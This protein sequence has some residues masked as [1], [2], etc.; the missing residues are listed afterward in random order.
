MVTA[1]RIGIFLS[2]NDISSL[3]G[4]HLI[5]RIFTG[6][7]LS[8]APLTA[9]CVR[10]A[11]LFEFHARRFI[12]AMDIKLLDSLKFFIRSASFLKLERTLS[13]YMSLSMTS[14]AG[15]CLLFS[16]CL[17][18]VAL[19]MNGEQVAPNSTDLKR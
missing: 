17:R 13:T 6:I 12:P 16:R 4:S 18:M 11:T 7:S 1:S 10:R 9:A 2:G 3:V 15:T 19:R 5:P 14:A 8:S